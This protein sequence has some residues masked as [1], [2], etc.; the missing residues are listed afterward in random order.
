MTMNKHP[1]SVTILSLL[2]LVTGVLGFVHHAY[3]ARPW[4][5]LPADAIAA[6]LVSLVAVI[7]GVWMLRGAN[8]ARWL[9]LAWMAFHVG[10]SALKSVQETIVHGVLLALFIYL[11]FRRPAREFFGTGA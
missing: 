3:E 5:T 2:M 6:C 1:I 9:T 7:C 4:H 10:L 11:L 8:W